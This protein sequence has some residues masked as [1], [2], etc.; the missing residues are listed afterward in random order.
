MKLNLGCGTKVFDDYINVDRGIFILKDGRK[1]E[2]DIICD[3][4]DGLPFDDETVEY[5]YADNVIEHIH[6]AIY[7]MQE[8]HRVLKKG[9]R[10]RVI[11]PHYRYHSSYN[12]PTHVHHFGELTIHHF[13]P[14]GFKIVEN[15]VY[16][17]FIPLP[18]KR[19]FAGWYF[20]CIPTTIDF[21]LEKEG[22]E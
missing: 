12:E 17:R 1:I 3:L 10:I 6:D 11:T 20:P 4:E 5:I 19:I 7:F 9:G 21:T 13:T 2:P 15:R 22:K 16:N 18:I 14:I 8:C